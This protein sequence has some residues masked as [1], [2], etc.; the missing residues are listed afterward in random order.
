[1][2]DLAGL[3]ERLEKATRPDRELDCAIFVATAESPFV[4]YYP[5]CVLAT[6]GGFSARL[7]I[8]DIE[9]FTSS[10]DAALTLVPEGQE[11]QLG[12]AHLVSTYWAEVI[13]SDCYKAKGTTPAIALC[14]AALKARATERKDKP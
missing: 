6:L 2:S 13:A 1:M 14:I 3:I 8:S 12:S 7:E 5:D 11:W 9:K 10:I 4:S